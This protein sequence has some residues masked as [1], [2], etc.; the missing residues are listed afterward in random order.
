MLKRYKIP[1]VRKIDITVDGKNGIIN[2]EFLA[3]F[4]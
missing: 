2:S 4:A 1:N 3:K